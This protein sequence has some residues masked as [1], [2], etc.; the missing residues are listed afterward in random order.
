[1][2]ESAQVPTST[3]LSGWLAELAQPTG[4]PGG[5]AASGVMLGLAAALLRMVAE[6]TPDDPQAAECAARL[7]TRRQQALDAAEADGVSSA[8]FG[9]ALALPAEDP[10]RGE[11]VRDAAISAARSSVRLGD[12]GADLLPELRLMARIGNPHLAAD[13]GVAAEALAAGIAGAVI[14]VRANLQTARRHEADR[15]VLEA[16][17]ADAERLSAV[18]S[19][20]VRIA[21][22]TAAALER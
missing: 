6:Y 13:L 7:A 14:N 18:R 5:G 21:A 9:A 12:V 1:M 20:V 3:P 11:H 19:E 17:S 4:A 15:S 22:T 8:E 10:T 2:N 16:C